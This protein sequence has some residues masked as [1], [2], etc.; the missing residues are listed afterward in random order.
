MKQ[1]SQG[2]DPGRAV[3]LEK[4]KAASV[5]ALTAALAEEGAAEWFLERVFL[6]R[7]DLTETQYR[8]IVRH[9]ECP[10]SIVALCHAVRPEW[11]E[12]SA[13]MDRIHL[14][15]MEPIFLKKW[16]TLLDVV[17]SV[18]A[19]QIASVLYDDYY[20]AIAKNL[21]FSGPKRGSVQVTQYG[22]GSAPRFLIAHIV[23]R[24]SAA[25][26]HFLVEHCSPDIEHVLFSQGSTK[27]HKKLAAAT[28]LKLETQQALSTS[29]YLSVRKALAINP[30][31]HVDV[32]KSI[33]AG[34]EQ[35]VLDVLSD[36]AA[37]PSELLSGITA[38]RQG[39]A[40]K[41]T[42]TSCVESV[43]V[44]LRTLADPLLD[45]ASLLALTSHENPVV[46]A[47][48][49]HHHGATQ[50]VYDKLM[51][52][53]EPWVLA[54][55]AQHT[56]NAEDMARLIDVKH[57]DT[58]LALASNPD[59]PEEMR[60]TIAK[61]TR[62]EV[63]LRQLASVFVDDAALLET[64]VQGNSKKTPWIVRLKLA[65]DPD[66][67]KGALGTL[68]RSA[69][70]RYLAI[71]KAIARH[72][73]CPDAALK[74]FAYY[75]PEAL[76]IRQK[77]MENTQKKPRKP[78]AGKRYDKWKLDQQFGD[79]V[80]HAC[81]IDFYM[82]GRGAGEDKDTR[83]A[84][85]RKSLSCQYLDVTQ[86][87][88]LVLL[89]DS[90][91]IRRFVRADNRHR[92]PEFVYE[93]LALN[94]LASV[95]KQLV[96]LK[97]VSS[98]LVRRLCADKDRSVQMAAEKVAKKRKIKLKVVSV[99]D[100]SDKKTLGNKAARLDL[101][102]S[103]S[104]L[105]LIATLVA[106]K[107]RDVRLR[108]IDNAALVDEL[109]VQLLEDSDQAVQFA[110]IE[111][112][113]SR[114]QSWN[115]KRVPGDKQERGKSGFTEALE[116]RIDQALA[117]VIASAS[118][119]AGRAAARLMFSH[120]L[121][122]KQYPTGTSGIDRVIIA[123]THSVKLMETSWFEAQRADV[124]RDAGRS[125]LDNSQAPLALLEE[126]ISLN[127]QMKDRLGRCK[128]P[129]AVVEFVKSG[130]IN[131][132]EGALEAELSADQIR[133][134]LSIDQRN[135]NLVSMQL[136]KL[137]I[138]ELRRLMASDD[139]VTELVAENAHL[140]MALVSELRESRCKKLHEQLAS[141]PM[142]AEQIDDYLAKGKGWRKAVW[143][144]IAGYQTLSAAQELTL[145]DDDSSR[146][147]LIYKS[148]TETPLRIATLQKL[149]KHGDKELR[150]MAQ[151]QLD[152]RADEI[153]WDGKGDD[154]IAQSD[155]HADQAELTREPVN[156][157]LTIKDSLSLHKATFGAAAANRLLLELGILKEVED[158]GDTVK[159][160]SKAGL[161]YGAMQESDLYFST[162]RYY[163]SSFS[164]LLDLMLKL[165]AKA[166]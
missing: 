43:Q 21:I 161:A 97:W 157:L 104:D 144:G 140:P 53:C 22:L 96:D 151:K 6:F 143:Y 80:A 146:W 62:S 40:A 85:L 119:E 106:D 78:V 52:S 10:Q 93:A 70:F 72:A 41:H 129:D 2:K 90:H 110:A 35:K 133:D 36:N 34:N 44:L 27:M 121:L 156:E 111:Q 148:E 152:D 69:D 79:G 154:E 147:E 1:W 23:A 137:N 64:I 55:V 138:D 164:E 68:H 25:D 42:G 18:E 108:I 81:V 165:R 67:A 33:I 135:I 125:L 136:Y 95:R 9:I 134:L 86:A 155:E 114:V 15:C 139:K 91:T 159:V 5:E 76:K 88:N 59:L 116:Q 60:Q 26:I 38:S 100:G 57:H 162:P 107:T 124:C 113:S 65:L 109:L 101:A 102:K 20:H 14:L 71:S 30:D 37:L 77:A 54:A 11:V 141:Y 45:E 84:C 132:N 7:P 63:V 19:E 158:Y 145:A 46:R 117:G 130:L 150:R 28:G 115:A 74:L 61:R 3:A 127:P 56:R 126:V 99:A 105:P 51:T 49:A 82:K 75:M 160:L 32:M 48:T 149:T 17:M 128:S 163:Q 16:Q 123:R 39:V 87:V 94:R 8:S 122:D 4:I 31:C 12:G 131:R 112:L 142:T 92:F 13:A 73:N 98:D 120:E 166:A 50:A 47:A 58:E 153:P 66:T 103:T 83:D 89:E 24:D 118:E 29:K